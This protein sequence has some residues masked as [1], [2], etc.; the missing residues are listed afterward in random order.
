MF[1]ILNEYRLKVQEVIGK[2]IA[3]EEITFTAEKPTATVVDLMEA[4]KASVAA[5]ADRKGDASEAK[6]KKKKSATG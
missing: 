1:L 5:A 6:P 4:L 3:G 2:K